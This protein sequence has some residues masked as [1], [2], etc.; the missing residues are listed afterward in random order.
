MGSFLQC[1]SQIQAT[2]EPMQIVRMQTE[3]FGCQRVVAARLLHRFHNESPLRLKDRPMKSEGGTAGGARPFCDRV[4]QIL[5]HDHF[6][7]SQ[8]NSALDGV[9]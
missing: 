1:G 7:R 2:D 6:G 3:Q 4:G 5:G 8:D 9:L